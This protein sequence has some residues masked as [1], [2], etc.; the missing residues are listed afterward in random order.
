MYL[1]GFSNSKDI[2][3]EEYFKLGDSVEPMFMAVS[4][5]DVLFLE[6]K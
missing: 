1:V 5:F 3:P 2:V 4:D 6:N